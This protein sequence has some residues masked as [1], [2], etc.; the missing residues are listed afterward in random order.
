[1]ADIN[2]TSASEAMRGPRQ[3]TM[4]HIDR[5]TNEA[6]MS[7]EDCGAE[8]RHTADKLMTFNLAHEP[9]CPLLKDLQSSWQP[10]TVRLTKNPVKME[11]KMRVACYARYS[12]DLQRETSIDDQLAVAKRYASEREWTVLENHVYFGFSHLRC[13]YSREGRRPAPALAARIRKPFDVLLVDDSS[14]IARDIADAIRTMQTLTLAWTSPYPEMN[15]HF[16]G[17]RSSPFTAS[18]TRST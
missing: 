9:W 6:V 7:C 16:G 11:Q 12:S 3:G 14:R 13:G 10:P 15:R 2:E 18:S 17:M 1:M 4:F 5:A 8:S